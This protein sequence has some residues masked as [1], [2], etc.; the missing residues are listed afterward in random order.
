MMDGPPRKKVMPLPMPDVWS[1][2]GMLRAPPYKHKLRKLMEESN[3][4]IECVPPGKKGKPVKLVWPLMQIW[5][6]QYWAVFALDFSKGETR[7]VN[8]FKEW[9]RLPEHRE[10]LEEHEKPRSETTSKSLDRLKDL[11]AWR[12]Y[13]ECGND[14]NKANGFARDNRKRLTAQEIRKRYKTKEQREQYR[15]F[16][17]KPFRDAKKQGEILPNQAD[18]F[19]EEADAR[20]AQ[21]RAWKHLV[22]IMPSE[23]KSPGPHMLGMFVEL[24][25]RASKE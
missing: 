2:T 14:W 8:E 18:F 23:F 13:R 3:R 7:L 17:P 4:V 9:L 20:E 15:P 16:D 10:R 24:E 6:S 1:L 22:E 5:K 21:A 11:A 19:G 12:L 25:K